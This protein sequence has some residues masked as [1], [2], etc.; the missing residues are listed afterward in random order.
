MV[1]QTRSFVGA[2]VRWATGKKLT[3]RLVAPELSLTTLSPPLDSGIIGLR[4][5]PNVPTPKFFTISGDPG[6]A[7]YQIF[8]VRK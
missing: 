6:R 4:M 3:N 8:D 5:G 7:I 2:L 1:H